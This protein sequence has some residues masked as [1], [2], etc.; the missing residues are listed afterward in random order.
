ME[1][2]SYAQILRRRWRL[3]V[4]VTVLAT[5]VAIPL[6]P[7]LAAV[8]SGEQPVT[9]AATSTLLVRGEI[10]YTLQQLALLAEE[11]EVP[12][13]AF[14]SVGD[15]VA[16]QTPSG[17]T[18]EVD[19]DGGVVTVTV[20][21]ADPTSAQAL[22]DALARE[23]ISY[24]GAQGE[25][26]IGSS[27]S[28][29][30]ARMEE[31]VTQIQAID[32]QLAA[33]PDNSLLE[34]EREGLLGAY[35]ALFQASQAPGQAADPGS[36]TLLDSPEAVAVTDGG[37]V[38]SSSSLPRR[39]ALGLVL[40]LLCGIATALIVDR[41]DTRVRDRKGVEDATDLPVLTELPRLARS[42]ANPDSPPL[43]VGLNQRSALAESYRS[44]RNALLLLVDPRESTRRV[45]TGASPEQS[46]GVLVCSPASSSDR[47]DAAA[48]L[49]AAFAESGRSVVLVTAPDGAADPT[50]SVPVEDQHEVRSMARA[51]SNVPQC[52][53][54][55]G[56]PGMKLLDLNRLTG[57]SEQL[58]VVL[59]QLRS[60]ADV[61]VFDAPPLLTTAD[62]M[63]F[64][65]SAD[66]AVLVVR[67]G[68]TRTFEADRAA[69]LLRLGRVPLVVPVLVAR[70]LSRLRPGRAAPL[71]PDVRV[72][73]SIAAP[74][75]S[76][77]SPT[78]QSEDDAVAASTAAERFWRGDRVATDSV[79]DVAPSL[80]RRGMRRSPLPVR[81]SMRERS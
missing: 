18:T 64:L 23:L 51:R 36:V 44:L 31:L 67:A 48:N 50:S 56:V 17:V 54:D 37:L 45:G 43:V 74:D 34:A 63:E 52:L 29:R 6:G 57:A 8:S 5:L 24:V 70:K 55:T 9:Y 53:L 68:D 22:S 58:E 1:S 28:E 20:D 78:E 80:A 15:G 42:R 46:L 25:A 4:L 79:V 81:R 32:A 66:V 69:D 76:E 47:V 72:P 33:D 26:A 12:R 11:G 75:G 7:R 49:A 60:L 41:F 2:V 39:L 21:A 3:L 10:G 59:P 71:A 35:A 62:A 13:R 38:S 77:E 19:P 16:A 27:S 30:D 65:P 14:A 61:V 73:P 40:G